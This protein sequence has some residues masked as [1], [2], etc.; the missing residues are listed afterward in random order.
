M[1]ADSRREHSDGQVP[2]VFGLSGGKSSAE[3]SW[4]RFQKRLTKQAGRSRDDETHVRLDRFGGGRISRDELSG[5]LLAQL[6]EEEVERV[7][8]RTDRQRFSEAF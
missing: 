7:D 3:P 2:A 8:G 5:D 1:H 6:A 4:S